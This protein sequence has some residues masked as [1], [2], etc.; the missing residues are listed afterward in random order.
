MASSAGENGAR[1]RVVQYHQQ[2]GRLNLNLSCRHLGILWRPRRAARTLPTAA[3]TYSGRT[4]SPF[5]CPSGVN[6]LS[7]NNLRDSGAVPQ[8]E[9]DQVAVVAAAGLPSPSIRLV[10]RR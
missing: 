3:T 7:R 5:R 2:L 4:C 8:I 9:K 1:R 6:S 10:V